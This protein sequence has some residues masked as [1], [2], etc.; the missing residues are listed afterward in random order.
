MPKARGGETGWESREEGKG[1]NGENRGK[2]GRMGQVWDTRGH[3]ESRHWGGCSTPTSLLRQPYKAVS[4]IPVSQGEEL[5]SE[6]LSNSSKIAAY[7]SH[8][9]MGHGWKVARQ[10]QELPHGLQEQPLPPAL[11]VSQLELS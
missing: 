8:P 3:H 9:C 5:D 6:R 7:C 10:E 1:V 2:E 4:P 11:A